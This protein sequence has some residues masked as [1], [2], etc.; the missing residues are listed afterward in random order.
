MMKDL[1]FLKVFVSYVILVVLA[2]AVMDFFLTPKVKDIMT[3]SVEDEMIGIAKTIALM[4]ADSMESKVPEIARQLNMRVT[5]ID[6]SGW[7]M[8]DSEADAAK[9]ENHLDRPEIEQAR[10]AGQGKASRFSV[11]LQESML[12]VALPIK[13]HG[14]MKGYLRLAHSLGKVTES[15]D[16]LYQALYLTMYI[17][18]IPSLVLAFIFSRKIGS[19]LNR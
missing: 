11:T 16:Q 17:I 13:E 14:Q 2:I 3:K 7:V 10:T 5:L 18:A 19:R 12:Y 15:L 1:R 6:P 9:M 4:P 8:A